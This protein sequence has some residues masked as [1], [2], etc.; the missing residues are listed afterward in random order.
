[1]FVTS[2]SDIH[3]IGSKSIYPNAIPGPDNLETQPM[4]SLP[5]LPA[6]QLLAKQVSAELLPG[7]KNDNELDE[8]LHAKTLVL[9]ETTPEDSKDPPSVEVASK[10]NEDS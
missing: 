7:T 3:I 2:I 9:G 4:E 6:E 10:P 8:L 5:T 1:M